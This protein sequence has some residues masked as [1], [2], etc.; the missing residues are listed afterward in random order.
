[1]I[2]HLRSSFFVQIIC[3]ALSVSISAGESGSTGRLLLLGDSITEGK[4]A[5]DGIGFRKELYL[6]LKSG[7]LEMDFVG[8]FGESPYE[9]HFQSGKK[10]SD[11][12][13]RSLGNGGTGIMDVTY[14]MDT[15]H[16]TMVSIHLGTND[17]NSED[18]TPVGPYSNEIGFAATQAGQ[19]G[20]LVDYLLRWNN[21]EKGS[22]LQAIL[23][24]LIIPIKYQDSLVAEFNIEL[25][26]LVHDFQDGSITGNLEP[27]F[28][29]DQYSRFCEHPYIW[30]KTWQDIMA[31]KMHPNSAGHQ[32]MAQ[33]YYDAISSIL[34]DK[35]NWFSD[36]TW[37]VGLNGLDGYFHS[38]GIAL[39]DITGD[40]RDEIYLTRSA[41]D[42]PQ[43]RDALYES[44]N[45]LPY[46]EIAANS[47]I[48][49]SGDSRG[50]IFADIDNDG[51][52]DL[53]NGNS[54]GR[55]RLYK[56]LGGDAFQDITETS[57][58]ENL[59]LLTTAVLAFD[60]EN[61]GDMDLYAVNSRT[62][63]ELYINDGTGK[64]ERRDRGAD[65]LEEPDI[66]SMSAGAADFDGDGDTDIY[67]VKRDAANKLFV[68]DGRGNFTEQA[69][70]AGIALSRR[71][72]GAVWVDL[73]NDARLDLLVSISA[74]AADPSPLLRNYRNRGDGTFEDRTQSVSIPMDGYS[75]LAADF[76]ND[77]DPDIITTNEK[78]YGAFY[79]NDGSWTFT[80]IKG[81]GSEIYAGDVRAAAAFDF[82]N[83]GD[84][85][86]L[87]ARSDAFNVFMQNNLVDGNHYLKVNAYGPKGEIGGLGTQVWLYEAGGLGDQESLLGFREISSSG[88][89]LAQNS[90]TQHFGLGASP[91][92]DLLARFTDGSW[93][94]MRQ[95][96]AD[97]TVTIRPLQPELE[98]I[99][100]AILSISSGENQSAKVNTPLQELLVVKVTDLDDK[101]V[102]GAKVDFEVIAGDAQILL[103]DSSDEFLWIEAESGRL[104]DNLLWISDS[105]CSGS[106]FV[107]PSD[108]SPDSANDTL[109]FK[110]Y[111]PGQ[112]FAW[113]RLANGA[114]SAVVSF[115]F[116]GG[117]ERY[118]A[119]EK[120]DL[121]QWIRMEQPA[122]SSA[123]NYL[124]QGD[125]SLT[126]S[127]GFGRV[128]IDKVL[129]TSDADY[130]PQGMG[131]VESGS[132]WVSDE[133]GLVRR[134][135]QLGVKAGP[136]IIQARLANV[137]TTA[138][139]SS[140]LFHASALPGNAKT[141]EKSSG[142]EQKGETGIPL[143]QPFV[144]TVRDSFANPV[145][146]KQIE[147]QVLSGG[148]LLEAAG[149]V[150]SDSSGH[151]RTRL[152]PGDL[153]AVQQVA[154]SADG[155]S[156]SP[157]IFSAFVPIVAANFVCLGGDQQ[158]NTVD[159][160][161][162]EAVRF[163]V[164]TKLGSPVAAHPVHIV[165]NK[166]NG[167]IQSFLGISR[168]HFVGQ[169]HAKS[170]GK[171]L[172][173]L[174]DSTLDLS[175][176]SNGIVQ[177]LWRL[178]TLSG[179]QQLRFDAGDLN[180]SPLL[181]NAVAYPDKPA[182]MQE[183]GGNRQT[184][185]VG[186]ILP[187]PLQVKIIDKYENAVPNARTTFSIVEGNGCFADADTCATDSIGISSVHFRLGTKSGRNLIK[188][189][190]EG[191]EQSILFSVVG[192][193][194]SLRRVT[195]I[196]GNNQTG[197]A[198]HLLPQSI[199]AKASDEYDNPLA[200]IFLSFM[201]Q[202]NH[203]QMVPAQGSVTDTTGIA[204]SQWI[205]G[206]DPGEKHAFAF[207]EDKADSASFSAF[208]MPNNPPLLHIPD[209][210]TVTENELLT[211]TVA[212]FDAEGDSIFFGAG[213][214]PIW[215][216]YDSA[217][218]QQ[219]TW[220]PDYRQSGSYY[221]AFTARDHLRARS[222]KSV[223]IKVR[224]ANR[225]PVIVE[226]FPVEPQLGIL[227]SPGQINFSILAADADNDELHY[228]WLVNAET[229]SQ[230]SEFD[231]QSAL[232]EAGVMKV[233]A[234]VFD[235]EDTAAF[236]W[237]VHIVS[238][239][240][241]KY[242][243]GEFQPYKGVELEWETVS[244]TNLLGFNILRSI[245]Q[246]G[247]F[248][249]TGLLIA[250]KEEGQYKVVD[251]T[252]ESG[253]KWFY[254]LEV[255]ERNGTKYPLDQIKIIIAAPT[256]LGLEQNYPNPFNA[257]TTIRFE[258]PQAM[259]ISLDIFDLLGRRVK[260]L[261]A[262]KTK[263]GYHTCQWDGT[264]DKGTA[265]ASSI[266]Y[267]ILRTAQMTLKKKVTVIR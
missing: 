167:T 2:K 76:D 127:F 149:P 226:H 214:L 124:P 163:Q 198:G 262:G 134:L 77:G 166:G 40:L 175:T 195:A 186:A 99:H 255:F 263:A 217:G 229:V 54:P 51:D 19:M 123:A 83:D 103:P 10:I 194:G 261:V 72:N 191:I 187:E 222:Q 52:F 148:G 176:D 248:A 30:S 215:A 161:L 75:I 185:K 140:L 57:G 143:A 147:F 11:F 231:F 230:E 49:D 181:V 128:Q 247:P 110:T 141:M 245:S 227:H 192:E 158:A 238:E 207:Q 239:V 129:L 93:L 168:E 182:Q 7:G 126:L 60:A 142:D 155:V 36:R 164:Q 85:D 228:Q 174:G 232:F 12:Y 45:S 14:D 79:R 43:A 62:L 105:S 118:L 66:A 144:V 101:A 20:T 15:F 237:Q 29:C 104:S 100:P 204:Q 6:K 90:P 56:N 153:A 65:D 218:T 89:H 42:S 114:D 180:G 265:V 162:P 71:S 199:A 205:L 159:Q 251:T 3:L 53:F 221:P 165:V 9:G 82:D 28:L 240:V 119:I 25:S 267:C 125:H 135:L 86:F 94:A 102:S 252:C 22:E 216:S 81:T 256:L 13:P 34:T 74:S 122:G 152:I 32:L 145:P 213:N 250:F 61:D 96:S 47:G 236:I 169:S 208:A 203:G 38:Q 8:G 131:E 108:F 63:N 27:V 121:W 197:V 193:P 225:P 173:A 111:G 68:N 177:V 132:P 80:E 92:C 21:G 137:D 219:F 223:N 171:H 189:A 23:V 41:T 138:I 46:Q 254:Q 97:Q 249:S 150:L 4:F 84:Q 241:L 264:N 64:F 67:I 69:E 88:G 59:D 154:A 58:I 44:S 106:S 233:A 242:F 206:L 48:E 107:T 136:I 133:E 95:I 112:Y 109:A 17:L 1:L 243:S 196:A 211:F 234:L 200:G 259:P 120:T 188:A 116:D 260:S 37:D 209:S 91:A 26:R 139:C 220:T 157:I 258:L 18:G 5:D 160:A 113:L 190:A 257:T 24:S 266:Y 130:S 172:A 98:E 210:L 31:D 178:G 235:A 156:G 183:L 170:A 184:A 117:S 70:Q 212:A 179:T 87:A 115:S 35:Q 50:A 244:A 151:A 202:A 253:D 33:V 201:A 39:A 55:N 246:N 78:D 224:N 146:G 16:P 73:D